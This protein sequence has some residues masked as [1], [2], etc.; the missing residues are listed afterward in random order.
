M[1]KKLLLI[2]CIAG[3]YQQSFFGYTINF[4]NSDPNCF[5]SEQKVD[6][7]VGLSE[8]S[9]KNYW[10]KKGFSDDFFKGLAKSSEYLKK[11]QPYI[12]KGLKYVPAVGDVA[13]GLVGTVADVHKFLVVDAAKFFNK[14][15]DLDKE[16]QKDTNTSVFKNVAKGGNTTVD[17]QKTKETFEKYAAILKNPVKDKAYVTIVGSKDKNILLYNHPIGINETFNFV[18]KKDIG[19]G[20]C[21]AIKQ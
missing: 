1:Y 17:L 15:F 7:L 18:V 12:E 5:K 11:A 20:A 6:I 4:K 21:V 16:W 19:S 13:S 3:I 14:V 8:N 10:K 2:V 9:V